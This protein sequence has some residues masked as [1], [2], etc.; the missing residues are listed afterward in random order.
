MPVWCAI[1]SAVGS[2]PSSV[3]SLRS[4]R[5]ILLGDRLADPPGRVGRELEALAVVELLGRSHEAQRALLDQVQERETLV[6]VV[7]GDRDDEA[8]V[9]LDHLLLGVEVAALD[10]AG[11]VDFLLRRE[12]AHLADVLEEQLEAVRR[13]VRLEVERR[14]LATPALVRRALDLRRLERGVDF[15]DQLDLGALQVAVQLFDVGL[16]EVDLRDR[17]GDLG[18]REHTHLL[19]LQ[20]QALDFF[21][22]LEV[23]Y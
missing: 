11:E 13:H 12:Q 14:L 19:P 9:G 17:R 6:A 22:F 18:E 5:P 4:A 20:E 7:L 16:V 10:A 23:N 3:T 15:L 1:S 8:E 2:R 21:E